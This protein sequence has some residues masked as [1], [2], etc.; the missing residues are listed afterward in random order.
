[1][2]SVTPA[3]TLSSAEV[4][5][6]LT[7]SFNSGSESFDYLATGETLTLTYTV[8]VTDNNNATDDPRL[9]SRLL[10]PMMR[11]ISKPAELKQI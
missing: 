2:L 11:H 9:P 1:M 4:V 5:D 8:R 6:Q 7:W 3:S 10:E